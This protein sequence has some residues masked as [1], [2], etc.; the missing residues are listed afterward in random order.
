MSN[1]PEDPWRTGRSERGFA[2]LL[3][4]GLRLTTD[5]NPSPVRLLRVSRSV[6]E[7]TLAD[8][9]GRPGGADADDGGDC[10]L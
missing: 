10:Y 7:P 4:S 2:L 8:S 3:L 1:S 6:G 5:G 9:G